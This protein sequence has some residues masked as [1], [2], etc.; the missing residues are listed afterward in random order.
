VDK[1]IFLNT[2]TAWKWTNTL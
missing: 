1:I 2:E